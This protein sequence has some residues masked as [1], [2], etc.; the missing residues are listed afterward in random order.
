VRGEFERRA[1]ALADVAAAAARL[2]DVQYKLAVVQSG[3][4]KRRVAPRVAAATTAGAGEKEEEEEEGEEGGKTRDRGRE[5][6]NMG[7]EGDW[8]ALT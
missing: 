8:D 2:R 6:E 1:D 3:R 7:R 5:A 4:V